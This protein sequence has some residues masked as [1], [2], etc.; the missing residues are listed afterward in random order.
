MAYADSPE[1]GRVKSEHVTVIGLDPGFSS[2]GFCTVGLDRDFARD[3][4]RIFDVGLLET[5]KETKKGTVLNVEDNFR[6]AREIAEWID[7]YV[8]H[9]GRSWG[10][11]VAIAAECFSPPRNAS[12]AAKVALTWGVI[13]G[14][15]VRHRI[16]VAQCSPQQL[17]VAIAKSKTASKEDIKDALDLRF[18]LLEDQL[19]GIATG[20]REHPYDAVGAALTCMASD[21]ITA[22][23][24]G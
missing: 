20:K 16:P 10:R 22:A 18:P 9:A 6:R 11:V 7:G 4:T 5:K 8:E 14:M 13:A 17:K 2:L 19:E 1:R 21:M 23:R 12:V 3:D 24:R 15:S